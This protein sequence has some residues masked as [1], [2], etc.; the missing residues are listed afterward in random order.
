MSQINSWDDIIKK[1]GGFKGVF[2]Y[3]RNNK[4]EM[5]DLLNKFFIGIEPVYQYIKARVV[6]YGE[7]FSKIEFPAS[8]DIMRWGGIVNGGVI[9]TVIDLAIGLAV[10]T[11]NNGYNQYTAELK[12]NFLQ[13][14]K[15]GPFTSIGRVI[16]KGRT[17]VVG[18]AEVFDSRNVLCAKG[19]GTWFIL[20]S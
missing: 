1:Y 10:M 3:F 2:D 11:V 8:K 15:E 18:E 6:D 14:L 4:K 17:L 13:P 12:V 16:R 7:G 19:I 5:I 9:M 20:T